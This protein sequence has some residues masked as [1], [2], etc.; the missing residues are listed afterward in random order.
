[1]GSC[2][3]ALITLS[4]SALNKV[5]ARPVFGIPLGAERLGRGRPACL[6]NEGFPSARGS[7]NDRS[8]EY[9]VWG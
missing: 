6:A 1:M 5:T 4:K 2:E 3:V 8:H 9:S 7:F